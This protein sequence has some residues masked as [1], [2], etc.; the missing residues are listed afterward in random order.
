[1]VEVP[2][3]HDLFPISP[4][5]AIIAFEPYTRGISV[6]RSIEAYDDALEN[7]RTHNE[8]LLRF[9]TTRFDITFD[10]LNDPDMSGVSSPK[11]K[12]DLT[13]RTVNGKYISGLVVGNTMMETEALLRGGLHPVIESDVYKTWSRDETAREVKDIQYFVDLS[14]SID[15][16]KIADEYVSNTDGKDEITS[17]AEPSPLDYRDIAEL[18]E[19][20]RINEFLT[21][22]ESLERLNRYKYGR[23]KAFIR[24]EPAIGAVVERCFPS[25][26][27]N[28]SPL[29]HLFTK[30]IYDIYSLFRAHHEA[31]KLKETFK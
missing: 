19:Q 13:R 30:G 5:A 24:D 26:T 29:L 15:P 31:E 23:V 11:W 2:V 25:G 14:L 3:I 8:R 12:L 7:F 1:M 21:R 22:L 6:K 28:T 10:M 16:D 20:V 9:L 4:E 27:T 18:Q 17:K